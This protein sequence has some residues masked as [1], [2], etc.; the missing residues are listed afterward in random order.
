MTGSGIFKAGEENG[1]VESESA[2]P[3]LTNKTGLRMYQVYTNCVTSVISRVF[4]ILWLLTA[5]YIYIYI[6]IYI[7]HAIRILH[8]LCGS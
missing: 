5:I 6:S 4:G 2:D 8:E 1:A 7:Y 3:N